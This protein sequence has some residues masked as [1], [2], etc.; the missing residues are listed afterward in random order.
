M[1]LSAKKKWLIA[2]V[3]SIL[4][5]A[6][7]F[8]KPL[9]TAGAFLLLPTPDTCR[10]CDQ[11]PREVPCLLNRW[12]GEVGELVGT[13]LPGKFQFVGCFGAMGGWDSDAQR[14]WVTVPDAQDG[15]NLAAFCRSCRFQIAGD[16]GDVFVLLDL[17]HPAE[18]VTYPL[19]A[20]ET[21]TILGWSVSV[22]T[23]QVE[24]SFDLTVS[25][26]P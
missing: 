12:T 6:L 25:P 24:S 19:K 1:N 4:L 14:A 26:A 11:D 8:W 22:Q 5:L 13:P 21:H 15:L 3:A 2:F 23:S 16:Q 9:Y 17:S 10:L 18:P 20:G 7:L